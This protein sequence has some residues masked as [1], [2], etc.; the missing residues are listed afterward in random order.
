MCGRAIGIDVGGTKTLAAVVETDTGRV[1]E[2]QRVDTAAAEG[3]AAVLE[4]CVAMAWRLRNRPELANAPIGVALCE[5]VD[6]AGSPVSAATVDWIGLDVDAA[7]GS[8]GPVIV[9]SDVRA[10][11]IAEARFGVG[12][13]VEQFVYLTVGTGIADTLMLSGV[14]HRGRGGAAILLAVTDAGAQPV[15]VRP[16]TLGAASAAVGAAL[17]AS[18]TR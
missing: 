7:F 16:A 12:A 4:R 18:K 11:S 2:V 1:V 10:A 3:G 13:D 17:L 6:P 8:L 9:E 14:P 15:E 5:F